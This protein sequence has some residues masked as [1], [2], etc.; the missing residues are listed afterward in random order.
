MSRFV[1]ELSGVLVSFA[2][3]NFLYIAGSDLVP[4]LR[5]EKELSKGLVQLSFMILGVLLLYLLRFIE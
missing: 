5:D 4:E 3:G 1:V 2:L